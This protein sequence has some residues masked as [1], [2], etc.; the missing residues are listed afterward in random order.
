MKDESKLDKQ[1]LDEKC[2]YANRK[3]EL[4]KWGKE[5]GVS[6]SGRS[7]ECAKGPRGGNGGKS[8]LGQVMKS[9][10]H[11]VRAVRRSVACAEGL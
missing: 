7:T 10:E 8:L 1:T 2:V 4:W 3:P 5:Q 9:L 6:Q 11:H